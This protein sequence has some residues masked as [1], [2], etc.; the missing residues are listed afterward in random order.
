M[1]YTFK[2][3]GQTVTTEDGEKKLLNFL[4]E[5]LGLVGT[6][7]G[8][9]S[10]HCGTCTVII[11]GKA[12]RSC[13]KKV[14]MVDGCNITTI[15]GLAKDG[16]L[17]PVQTAFLVEHAF[18]CGFCTPG[19]VLSVV[20]LLD[21]NSH[22]TDDEIKEALKGNLC[23]CTGYKQIMDAVHTAIAI[24]DGRRPNTIDNGKGWVG[25]SPVS[26]HGIERVTG[27]P[28]FTDDFQIKGELQGRLKLTDYPHAIIKGIDTSEAEKMPGV[29]R[30]FTHADIP[31][32]KYFSSDVFPQQ[33]FATEKAMCIGDPIALVVADTIEHADAACNAIK[34]DYEVLPVIDS[35]E[36][37]LDPESVRVHPET[38][39]AYYVAKANRGNVERGF[40]QSDLIIEH[41]FETQRVEHGILELDTA[42]ATIGE[43]GRL[44]LYATG[45]NPTSAKRDVVGAL[46]IDPAKVRYI[47]R[48]AGGAF[49]GREDQVLH[50]FASLACWLLQKPVRVTITRYQTGALTAKRHPIK[51]H[52]KIGVKNDGTI[53]ATQGRALIDSGA[54]NGLGDFLATCTAAMGA[55]PYNIPNTDFQST[56]VYTNNTFGYCFRGYGSTQ[57]TACNETMLDK[58]AEALHMDPYELR[59]KNAFVLGDQTPG[60]QILDT[61][62]AIQDCLTA[63]HEGFVKDVLPEPSAPGKKVGWGIAAAYKNSGFG[64]GMEDGAGTRITLCDDGKFIMHTGAVECGNGVDTIICQSAATSLG[65]RYD[66]V[67]IG[68]VDDDYSPYS[69]G[70]T[71]ASRSTF[72]YGNSAKTVATLMKEKMINYVA[73]KCGKNP[74][75]LDNDMDGIFELKGEFRMSWKE[76]AELAKKNGD[77]LTQDYYW[78]DKKLLPLPE[79]GNNIANNPDVK[80]YSAYIFSSQIAVVEVDEET[81]EVKVLKMYAASDVGKAMNPALV[82]GQLVGS[83][84]MGLGNCLTEDFPQE[85]GFIINKNLKSLHMPTIKEMPLE[86]ESYQI[87]E[88]HPWGPWGAKGFT[89][90]ALNPAT[91]AVLNAIYDAV[92]VRINKLPVDPKKLAAAIKGDKIYR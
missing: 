46:D 34:V 72:G 60:G 78:V 28:L 58:V 59:K 20:A 83:V 53:M 9:S 8:C 73:E 43:D 6:K 70:S 65:I 91:P 17:H 55:G 38:P 12:V 50:I 48:P 29:V 26:K 25:E 64:N 44:V 7:D 35:A 75:L 16:E 18:Q 57:V 22:P 49:G 88:H 87:E 92:G 30:I 90:G 86:I 80:I 23:R 69:T 15:E 14:R 67:D 36:A 31:G 76:V 1:S 4:R 74:N 89:E 37:G 10:G 39:N 54:Y 84:V 61:D 79:D 27:M 52:Y 85:G 42:I 56:V 13:L 33:I 68:P 19:M 5:D 66:D 45:Q 62:V 82:E 40:A 32:K 63:V 3:N 21:A 11:D 71:S 81:G 47:N 77:V 2:V 24:L 51:F 41:D